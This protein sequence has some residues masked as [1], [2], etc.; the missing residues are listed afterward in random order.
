MP[1]RLADVQRGRRAL[2][3][4]EMDQAEHVIAGRGD[5]GMHAVGRDHH[6]AGLLEHRRRGAAR[7]RIAA[8]DHQ[9][10]AVFADQLVGGE[11]RL[12]GLGLVV[13]ADEFELLPEHAAGG[14]DVLDRHLAAIC[15][16]L[17][18]VAA[19][20]VSGAWKP[21]LI[22]ACAGISVAM[23]SIRTPAKPRASFV[24][25]AGAFEAV[26]QHGFLHSMKL[27]YHLSSRGYASRFSRNIS[28]ARASAGSGGR[29]R[30]Q[31]G[32]S[33]CLRVASMPS[34]A[35][36]P[37]CS[38]GSERSA[39]TPGT[40][41]K[42][43][44]GLARVASAHST[45][46]R[47]PGIDVVVDDDHLLD[48][49]DRG[50]DRK[51]RLARLARARRAQRDHGV[52]T[53]GAADADRDLANR[54]HRVAD[55]AQQPGRDGDAAEQ[56]ML[57]MV[58]RQDDLKD[59]VAAAR[60]PRERRDDAGPVIFI[61]AVELADR[62]FHERLAGIER[63]FQHAFAMRRHQQIRIARSGPLPAVR[64][65]AHRRS[66]VRRRPVRDRDMPPPGPPG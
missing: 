3:R 30:S 27:M 24:F 63:A 33:P 50:P 9:L 14:V 4:P 46:M 32:R 62:P 1:E 58:A 28:R 60:Q 59:R 15:A 31:S 35:I 44:S 2:R 41:T 49:I 7:G 18:S 6:H 56:A 43:R 45:W 25:S 36:V 38:S 12:V 42:S 55:G 54:R 51:H 53:A 57:G 23:P 22:S 11:D 65:T 39:R 10:D 13:I 8:V 61:H 26:F 19:G 47:I 34:L 17:P 52:Q 20:P 5:V 66:E 40:M 64:P 16:D 48:Q 29:A 21:I 37:S